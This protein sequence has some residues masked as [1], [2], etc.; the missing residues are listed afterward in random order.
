MENWINACNALSLAANPESDEIF[1]LG[2]DFK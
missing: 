1:Y 2:N